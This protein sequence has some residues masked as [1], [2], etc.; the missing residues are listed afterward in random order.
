MSK[1]GRN[2]E[3]F[4]Q[5][6]NNVSEKVKKLYIYLKT[7]SYIEG[8]HFLPERYL[9][10]CRLQSITGIHPSSSM[11]KNICECVKFTL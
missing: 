2:R 1:D 6:N 8:S 11:S 9:Y 7:E 5:I 10:A 4:V 3:N